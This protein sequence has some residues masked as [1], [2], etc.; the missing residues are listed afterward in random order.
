MYGFKLLGPPLVPQ[1]G[2]APMTQRSN[3][4]QPPPQ[5][6]PPQRPR[7]RSRTPPA[8]QTQGLRQ[9]PLRQ[10]KNWP[11]TTYAPV[12][13][14][15]KP[16]P[17]A[18][19]FPPL[20]PPTWP[21]TGTPLAP[22]PASPPIPSAPPPAEAIPGPPPAPPTLPGPP[23]AEAL[24][25]PPHKATPTAKAITGG[26][27]HPMQPPHRWVLPPSVHPLPSYNPAPA[28][29]TQAPHNIASRPCN[30]VHGGQC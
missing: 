6:P 17:I 11:K 28:W 22:H 30:G 16:S 7:S 12:A 13:G 14:L 29:H 26:F 24:A 1:G 3:T 27:Y 19:A 4:P 18:V 21:G 5:L 20:P 2:A 10:P 15:A 23:P 8:K 9:P 25:S